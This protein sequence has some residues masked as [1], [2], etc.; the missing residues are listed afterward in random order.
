[1]S[2][3]R[4]VR[5]IEVDIV[6]DDCPLA[7]GAEQRAVEQEEV[8]SQRLSD[9]LSNLLVEPHDRFCQALSCFLD[10]CNRPVC[11]NTYPAD[12]FARKAGTACLPLVGGQLGAV[13]DDRQGP[14]LGQHPKSIA[15]PGV[16]PDVAESKIE[17]PSFAGVGGAIRAR[18][19]GPGGRD[20]EIVEHEPDPNRRSVQR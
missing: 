9:D 7:N 1:M 13:T 17:P 10:S 19:R 5:R 4:D 20:L 8:V 18:G 14:I 11:P 6:A 15:G 3:G 2:Q 16:G 12:I